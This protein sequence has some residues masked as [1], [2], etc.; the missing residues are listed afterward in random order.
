MALLVINL[1]KIGG[2]QEWRDT[3]NQQIPGLPG[4]DE[5]IRGRARAAEA[6]SQST[7]LASLHQNGKDQNKRR[8]NE[9]REEKAVNHMC[10]RW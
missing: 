4:T 2:A 1:D 6:G 9:D 3:F 7:T 5:G 10:F 8:N